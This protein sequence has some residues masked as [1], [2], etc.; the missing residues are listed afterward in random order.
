[1]QPLQNCLGQKDFGALLQFNELFELK[2][3]KRL[4]KANMTPGNVPFIGAIDSNNGLTAFIGQEALHPENTITV[5]YNGNGVAE[6]FYQ[7]VPYRY[8]D[9]VNV[10][11]PRFKLTPAIALFIATAIRQ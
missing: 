4:T 9:D 3:G 2:K 5:N 1:M 8:T 7:P 11:Y 10:L 6:A